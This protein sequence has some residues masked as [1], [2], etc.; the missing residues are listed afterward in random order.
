MIIAALLATSISASYDPCA[1]NNLAWANSRTGHLV[2]LAWQ[3]SD[4]LQVDPKH[5]KEIDGDVE[6]GKKVSAEVD[7]A[8]KLSDNKEYNERIQRIGSEIASIANAT[9]A[10]VS[11]GDKQFT[12]LNY[13][14]KVIQG[15][16]V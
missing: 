15:T 9:R 2:T 3:Q 11:W 10:K 13:T 12:P 6:L 5:Q 16:D 14:F 8:E 7:K 1:A 4:S